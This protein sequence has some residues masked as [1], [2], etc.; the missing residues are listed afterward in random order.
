MMNQ[1]SI[2]LVPEQVDDII[3]NE[4]WQQVK[5]NLECYNSSHSIDERELYL[6]PVI[7]SL[8]IVLIHN[9]PHFDF[10]VL[11]NHMKEDL[12]FETVRCVDHFLGE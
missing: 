11:Y 4:L 5:N 2:K 3:V 12:P 1:P 9:M 10:T 8:L 6:E 7:T